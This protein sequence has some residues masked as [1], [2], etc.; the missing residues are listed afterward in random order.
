MKLL[1]TILMVLSCSIIANAQDTFY[2][3][4]KQS[5]Q[6]VTN[7]RPVWTADNKDS[8]VSYTVEFQ[9]PGTNVYVVLHEKGPY[10]GTPTAAYGPK[11]LVRLIYTDII[12]IDS[13]GVRYRQ[14]DLIRY[15][16]VTVPLKT[17]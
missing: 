10:L 16:G 15:N 4:K 9:K 5:K 12:A 2:V 13:N 1:L 6:V 8:I 7:A 11:G 14:P 3:K 17:K